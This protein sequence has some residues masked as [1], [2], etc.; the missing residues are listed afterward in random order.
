MQWSEY[1]EHEH[2]ITRWHPIESKT[3]KPSLPEIA[4]NPQEGQVQTSLR[5]VHVKGAAETYE[6]TTQQDHDE[7][8]QGRRNQETH[9]SCPMVKGTGS[10]GIEHSLVHDQEPG[11]RWQIYI[12]IYTPRS[13][14]YIFVHVWPD[15]H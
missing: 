15:Q 10:A 12:Y 7:R 4:K 8:G 9:P 13:T 6:G 3:F 14:K 1:P 11:L 5:H 2:L